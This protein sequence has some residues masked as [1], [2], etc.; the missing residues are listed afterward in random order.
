MAQEDLCTP[1]GT[2]QVSVSQSVVQR[3]PFS[4]SPNLGDLALDLVE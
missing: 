4:E 3:P 1:A 2:L